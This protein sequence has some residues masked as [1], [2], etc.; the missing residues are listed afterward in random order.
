MATLWIGNSPFCFKFWHVDTPG[1]VMDGAKD[2]LRFTIDGLKW[3]LFDADDDSTIYEGTLK[4]L[5]GRPTQKIP[6]GYQMLSDNEFWPGL[7]LSIFGAAKSADG[8]MMQLYPLG[9]KA[10][11]GEFGPRN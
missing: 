4:P 3:R 5:Y 7:T 9:S 10:L 6:Y 1:N 2:N 8:W 11:P